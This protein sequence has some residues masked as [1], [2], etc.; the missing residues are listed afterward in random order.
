MLEDCE[1]SLL[2]ARGLGLQGE[3]DFWGVNHR[4]YIRNWLMDTEGLGGYG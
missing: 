1:G 4:G 2:I 3:E